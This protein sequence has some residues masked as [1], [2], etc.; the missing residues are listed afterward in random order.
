MI[1]TFAGIFAV[2]LFS[3]YLMCRFMNSKNRVKSRV[4]SRSFDDSHLDDD[5][6]TEQGDESRYSSESGIRKKHRV[7]RA[8]PRNST[9]SHRNSL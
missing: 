5:G 3:L 9:S 1:A 8:K 2:L 4:R 6:D 7:P